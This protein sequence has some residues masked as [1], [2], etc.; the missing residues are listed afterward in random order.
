[1]GNYKNGEQF[2]F[3]FEGTVKSNYNEKG[4]REF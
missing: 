4:V 2:F 3:R 1:M